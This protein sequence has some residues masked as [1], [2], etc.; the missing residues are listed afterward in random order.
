MEEAIRG[1]V[2]RQGRLTVPIEELAGDDDLYTAGLT[3]HAAVNVMLA[4]EDRF[5]IEFPDSLISK[6]TFATIDSLV[7]A[8]QSLAG[9]P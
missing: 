1:I 8:V 2:A 9:S 6:A 5:A 3:S 7:T 4:I